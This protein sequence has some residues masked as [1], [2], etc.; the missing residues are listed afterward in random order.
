[1]RDNIYKDVIIVVYHSPSASDGDFLRFLENVVDLMIAKNQCNKPTRITKNSQTLIDL[2]FANTK[3]DE[4]LYTVGEELEQSNDLGSIKDIIESV[5]NSESKSINTIYVIENR[6]VIEMFES[7]SV[8][9]L[10]QIVMALPQKKGTDEGISSDILKMSLHVIKNELLKVINDSL[11][12]GI[13]PEEWKTST[14]IPIPK[15]EKP[16]K[17]K[18]QSG[19]RKCHLCETAIQNIIDDW[20][21]IVSEE[22]MVGVIFLD[23]KR[24]FETVDRTRLLGK[25]EQYRMRGMV[26]EWFKSYLSNRTQQIRFNNQWSKCIKT[27]YGVPQGS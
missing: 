18:H 10:E 25:L 17:A 1:M 20:K 3:V 2:V 23:L 13:C 11:I 6:G 24:V 4:F 22:K 15:V 12:K 16:K 26:L 19:F 9:K 7:I 5:G 21:L 8:Q 14:I 27:E